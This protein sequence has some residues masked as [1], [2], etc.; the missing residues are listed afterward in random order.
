MGKVIGKPEEYYQEH[1]RLSQAPT[2][3]KAFSIPRAPFKRRKL[4]DRQLGYERI[5]AEEGVR[6]NGDDP[7]QQEQDRKSYGAVDRILAEL[8]AVL[9]IVHVPDEVS[10]VPDEPQDRD[11]SQDRHEPGAHERP[12]R[13][14]DVLERSPVG[15]AGMAGV[16]LDGPC[17][18]Q[19][20]SG[21]RGQDC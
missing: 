4:T 20:L 19:G 17:L 6:R 10:Q 2:D 14:R 12:D 11:R 1:I 3:K 9:H 15:S 18:R 7:P 21:E 13:I 5:P 16:A 8:F